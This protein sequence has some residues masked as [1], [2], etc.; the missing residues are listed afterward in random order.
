MTNE[1]NDDYER[2]MHDAKVDNFWEGA[3]EAAKDIILAIP[4]FIGKGVNLFLA[5]S[6]KELDNE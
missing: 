2:G 6:N 1:S 4:N 5:D 3:A